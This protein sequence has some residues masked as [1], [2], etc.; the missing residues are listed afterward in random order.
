MTNQHEHQQLR[1]EDFE[2]DDEDTKIE[3][4]NNNKTVVIVFI[5]VV[6]LL[7]LLTPL[8]LIY[9][10]IDAKVLSLTTATAKA[11]SNNNH[12]TNNHSI[13]S[14]RTNSNN[15]TNTIVNNDTISITK[16]WRD[17]YNMNDTEDLVVTITSLTDA[18]Q[19][20]FLLLQ[21]IN[22]MDGEIH[23]L[24]KRVEYAL[25]QTIST[26]NT[27]METNFTQHVN[28]Q[29]QTV[30][31]QLDVKSTLW[32]LQ[33]TGTFTI[34]GS[35][36][37]IYHMITHLRNYH[38]PIVQTKIMAILAMIPIYSLSSFFSLIFSD[39]E[40]LFAFCKDLYESY[41]IYTF[42]SLLIAIIGRGNRRVVIESIL[43]HLHHHQQQQYS[44]CNKQQQQQ[45]EHTFEEAESLLDTCQLYAMQF[46][47][48]RPI[49]SI[50]MI[51]A[52]YI[53]TEKSRWNLEYPQFY[54]L[55]IT[56]ASVFIAFQGLMKLYHLLQN[57]L[58]WCRP[59]SKFLCIKGIVFMTFWQSI[60]I[61]IVASS[62]T[63]KENQ[64][65]WTKRAQNF[66]ICMEMFVF[67]IIH[68]FVF[69]VKEWE[70]GYQYKL[71]QK[72]KEDQQL[73]NIAWK[74]FVNDVQLIMNIMQKK[75]KDKSDFDNDFTTRKEESTAS[76][77]TNDT[78][79]HLERRRRP[80][81]QRGL[82]VVVEDDFG[83]TNNTNTNEWTRIEK[84]VSDNYLDTD[85]KKDELC[86]LIYKQ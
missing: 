84:V 1:S 31:N 45:H 66:C 7:S 49:T 6:L 48:V 50:M 75:K 69:P 10:Q 42:V 34:L 62:I 9:H 47:F 82:D 57:D 85:K 59:F 16:D 22:D 23:T 52:D 5:V 41:C 58:Q 46:V 60:A 51:L 3:I 35:L 33:C 76:L 77:F 55:M 8:V 14:T 74:D 20:I 64:A 83:F 32:I 30:Q 25:N 21:Q 29:I 28:Q 68:C 80:R 26:I 43:P 2:H 36:I 44:C 65:E 17:E 11:P 72:Q 40:D 71:V 61:S 39:R 53:L 63:E 67:A 81:P 37:S 12:H 27:T 56:N 15:D 38:V 54:I 4:G 78:A 86:N 24:E 70:D 73:Q 18:T 79:P 19:Q 13:N